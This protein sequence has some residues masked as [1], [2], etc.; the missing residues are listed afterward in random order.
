MINITNQ[1]EVVVIDSFPRNEKVLSRL[2]VAFD[3]KEN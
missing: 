3:A 1:V 2:Q